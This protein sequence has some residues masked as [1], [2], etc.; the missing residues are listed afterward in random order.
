VQGASTSA[1]PEVEG[2]TRTTRTGAAEGLIG[3][4]ERFTREQ[5]AANRAALQEKNGSS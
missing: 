5:F 4:V 2:K 3:M 1:F